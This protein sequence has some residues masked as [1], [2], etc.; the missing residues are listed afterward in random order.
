MAPLYPIAP[1]G[2]PLLK[3]CLAFVLLAVIS[4]ATLAWRKRRPF[5]LVGWLWYLG[6]LFP[7]SGI[8]QISSDAAHADRYTYLPEIG[9]AIAVAWA[10]ADLGA[11]WEQRRM[12]AG[13][14]VTVVLGALMVCGYRQAACWRDG[15]S[16]WTR[17]LTCVPNLAPA[18]VYLGAALAR[19]G[20]SEPALEAVPEW[21]WPSRQ[22]TWPP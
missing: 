7:V 15:V 8:I 12:S 21:R 4:A 16:L 10:A 1:N 18:H 5:L 17:E 9:I 22:I 14:L 19:E 11:R 6:M 13:S 3:V 2:P 20:K